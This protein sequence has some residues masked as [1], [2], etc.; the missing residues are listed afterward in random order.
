MKFTKQHRALKAIVA[1]VVVAIISCTFI[2]NV[3]QPE[4]VY[5]ETQIDVT[6][7]IRVVPEETENGC[8]LVFG[9]AAPKSLNLAT[10]ATLTLKT[11]NYGE[12]LGIADLNEKL[13]VMP[14]DEM[15]T[16]PADKTWVQAFT[17]HYGF[18]AENGALGWTADNM[19]WTIWQS[20]TAVDINNDIANGAPLNAQVTIS[21]PSGEEELVCQIGYAMTSKQ[22]GFDGERPTEQ[23]VLKPL[24]IE[25]Y[26][27]P[28]I[29]AMVTVP[30]VF[31]YGDII[32]FEFSGLATDL[33]GVKDVYLCAKAVYN[34]GQE[35]EVSTCTEANKMTPFVRTLLDGTSYDMREKFIYPKHFFGLEQDAVIEEIYVWFSNADGTKVVKDGDEPYFIAQ[36]PGSIHDVEEPEGDDTTEDGD[37]ENTEQ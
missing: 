10:N 32:G 33:E 19:E 30:S 27:A 35:V 22:K 7:D 9:M 29:P 21:F 8:I 11:L 17:D 36:T 31:R 1:A 37:D 28:S 15:A 6:V 4:E 18:G 24:T 16:N 25:K 3:N 5:T 14:A 12:V 2:D 23:L 20:T 26:V 13:T 34:G